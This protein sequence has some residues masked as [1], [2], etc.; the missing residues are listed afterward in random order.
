MCV[1]TR[2]V[3]G[4]FGP[5]RKR[6]PRL[7]EMLDELSRF[8]MHR[9]PSVAVT[10]VG[11][12]TGREVQDDVDLHVLRTQ[13]LGDHGGPRLGVGRSRETS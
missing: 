6:A 9:R 3:R 1:V 12:D 10:G 2:N 4:R 5:W 13:P 8:V 7:L 11:D